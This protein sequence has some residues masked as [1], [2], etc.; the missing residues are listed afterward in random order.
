MTDTHFGFRTVADTEKTSLVRGV[1]DAVASK[2]D[3]MNDAMSMGL[4]R[5]WKH[6]FVGSVAIRPGMRCLDVAGGT[7]DIA[8]RL[9][10]RGAEQVTIC[11]INYLMLEEGRKRADNKN[12]LAGIEWLCGNAESLPLPDNQFHLYTIAFGIRNVTHI[13][14]ALAEAHRVL[15]PGG[16][17]MCL[18]FS[19]MP[20]ATLQKLYDAY[21]FNVIPKLGK[22]IA[23]E[24]EPYTY[25]VES[26]RKFPDQKRFS[27]MIAD[28]GFAQVR[29]TNL[30]GGVV[31]IHSGYKI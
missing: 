28:A 16:R 21:S 15:L 31:A 9:L 2:Y 25:L 19:Q 29:H 14:K 20:S 8:F 1:F 4:H 7:G 30:A 11:D 12:L 18:E 5:L 27:A 26:I 17:F 24:S 3:I 23:G 22:L 6:E 13:D 10:A